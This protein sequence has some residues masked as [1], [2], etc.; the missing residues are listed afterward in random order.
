VGDPREVLLDRRDEVPLHALH[1]VRVVLEADVRAVDAVD[2]RRGLA[3]RGDEVRPVLERVDRL[4]RDR[5]AVRRG[6]VGGPADVLGGE[7]AGFSRLPFP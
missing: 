6:L 3:R 2:E 1:V 4:D 7:S 5:D